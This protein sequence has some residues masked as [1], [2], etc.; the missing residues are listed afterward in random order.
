MTLL[1]GNLVSLLGC[2]LMVAVGFIRKKERILT[3]QCFQLMLMGTGNLILGAFSGVVANLVGIVRNLVFTK[4]QVNLPLKLLFIGIQLLLSL[5][6][7]KNGMIEWL[8]ILS[9]GLFTWFLDTKSERTLKIIIMITT[10][11][12]LVYDLWYCNYVAMT[13]DALTLISNAIGIFM[14]KKQTN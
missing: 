2:V 13:F 8:P 10:A 7:L 1:L 5:S 11:M 9:A 3:V 6:A 4:K 14:L 12:W